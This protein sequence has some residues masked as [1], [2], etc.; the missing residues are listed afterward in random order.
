MQA[1]AIRTPFLIA[2]LVLIGLA[3]LVEVGFG[4][5]SFLVGDS[6]KG[7]PGL[8]IGNLALLDGLLL[9]TGVLLAAPLVISHCG[10]AKVQGIATLIVGVVVLI[11]GIA[12]I[13][14]ATIKL[15]L[16]VGLLLAFPFGTIA[17]L[18]KYADFPRAVAASLLAV[19]MFCKLGFAV[20]LVLAHEGIL[21]NIPLILIIV[22]SL[23]GNIVVGLLHGIVPGILVSITDAVAAIVVVI[24]ALIWAIFF[25]IGAIVSIVK[26]AASLKA[27]GPSLAGG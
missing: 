10:H 22:T 7:P 6:G 24:L 2:A 11:V 20:C 9:F 3:V 26:L 25:L 27:A 5:A 18:A 14:V 1:N 15:T 21:K 13:V 16:M 17:Y 23:I 12:V 8:G 4:A 19:I